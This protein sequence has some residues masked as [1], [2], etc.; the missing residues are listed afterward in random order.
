MLNGPY[1]RSWA[2][3]QPVPSSQSIVT[4]WSVKIWPKPGLAS[5]AARWAAGTG[6]IAG[7]TAKLIPFFAPALIEPSCSGPGPIAVGAIAAA[8]HA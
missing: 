1:G 4:M 6:V 7:W 3:C 2:S 5:S 8:R